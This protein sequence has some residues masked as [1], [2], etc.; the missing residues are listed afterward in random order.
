MS[1]SPIQVKFWGVR[2]SIPTPGPETVRYG[3]NTACVEVRCGETL[4][5]LDAGSG[6]RLLGNALVDELK[7][8]PFHTHLL[9]SHTHW[10][11][12]QGFPFFKP[13]Y[14]PDK[15]VHLYG[16]S[17]VVESIRKAFWEQM[18]S[19]YFPVTMEEMSDLRFIE[20]QQKKFSINDVHIDSTFTNH[21]GG[22][23]AY[24]LTYQG[25]SVVW[26]TDHEIYTAQVVRSK[27]NDCA[28]MDRA[29][30][31]DERMGKFVQGADLLIGDTQYT[32]EEYPQRVS[33]GHSCMDDMVHFA[34]EYGVKHL[35]LFHHDPV[36]SD[37]QLDAMLAY[38]RGLPEAAQM[39]IDSAYEGFQINC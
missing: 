3:G 12:I 33:W 16:Y 38:A 5:V 27:P 8:K 35:A 11:H 34:A 9:I 4:I 17:G 22:C 37:D 15:H 1:E 19:A 13:A 20:M 10:D 39:K 25:H 2:G 30:M 21:P 32:K 18:Q 23:A 24:R 29:R 7:G 14:V 6:I 28:A 26:L 31:E 36:H